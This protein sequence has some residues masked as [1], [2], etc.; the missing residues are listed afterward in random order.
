MSDRLPVIKNSNISTEA[1]IF[2][3]ETAIKGFA[4]LRHETEIAGYLRI[5]FDVKYKSIWDCKIGKDLDNIAAHEKRP[6]VYFSLGDVNI[7]LFESGQTL[8]D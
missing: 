6:F 5:Q 8:D 7:L 3:V 1:Q 4:L 2:A